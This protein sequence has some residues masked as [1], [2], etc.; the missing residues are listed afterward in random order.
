MCALSFSER[1]MGFSLANTGDRPLAIDL[2][3]EEVPNDKT[4]RSKS[5]GASGR[6]LLL[7]NDSAIILSEKKTKHAFFP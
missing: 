1:I 3:P 7:A 4:K 2:P 6:F 5:E